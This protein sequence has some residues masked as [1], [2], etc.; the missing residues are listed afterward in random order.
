MPDTSSTEMCAASLLAHAREI[1]AT[2]QRTPEPP[3]PR[4]P[5]HPEPGPVSP[6]GPGAPLPLSASDEAPQGHGLS[7]S[8]P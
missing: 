6:L 8:A 1:E 7:V 4:Q 2:K 3:E 5:R